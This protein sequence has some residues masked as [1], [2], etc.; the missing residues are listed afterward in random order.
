M[1][2]RTPSH[3]IRSV[4]IARVLAVDD[5]PA[6]LD[7]IQQCLAPE[8]YDMYFAK[9]GEQAMAQLDRDPPQVVVCDLQMPGL[10]GPDLIR[11]I[12]THP[13]G[14]LITIIVMSETRDLDAVIHALTAGA[15]ETVIKPFDSFELRMRVHS[16]LAQKRLIDDLADAETILESLARAVESR[17]VHLGNHVERL[18]LYA[19]HYG[20]HLKLNGEDLR[21]LCRGATLHDLG[22]IAIPD[23]ILLA[24]RK[25]TQEE[26]VIMRSHPVRG[27]EL[28]RPM[29]TMAT[30]LPIIRSH[31]ERWDG[32][33]YPDALKAEA[34]P[35]LARYFQI[36]DVFDALTNKRPYRP[37]LAWNEAIDQLKVEEAKGWY[38]L[39]LVDAWKATLEANPY[40]L[41][42]LE[43][44]AS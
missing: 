3:S 2:V 25:L 44:R 4:R 6:A 9:T 41:R 42:I 15:N 34:I 11:R 7:L 8:G 19:L 43:T 26:W 27:E 1:S 20:K 28:C 14:A 33:G 18:Q 13:A 35:K 40:L 23:S 30:T 37:S 12:R 17:D 38:Q 32:S 24:P 36:L 22:K 21:A 10:G 31:H 29:R 39:G 5:D 16:A